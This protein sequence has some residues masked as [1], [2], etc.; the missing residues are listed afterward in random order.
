MEGEN[1]NEDEENK[2][3]NEE[4]ESKNE[5]EEEESDEEGNQQNYN[6]EGNFQG[7]NKNG[8]LNAYGEW[9]TTYKSMIHIQYSN[10]V[11]WTSIIL[12]LSVIISTGMMI[13]MPLM[14][15]TLLFG[16][17]AKMVVE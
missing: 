11:L 8:Y 5:E 3:E 12:I 13:Y 10:V 2:N 6:N 9:I 4:N 1:R 7:Q 14:P 17:S 15:D 16:E